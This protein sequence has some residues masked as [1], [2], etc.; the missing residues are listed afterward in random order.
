MITYLQSM[1]L[2]LLQGVSEL[3]PIS[4]LG[5]SV[6]FA[7][8]FGW[9]NIVKQ[10]ASTESFFL[11]YLVML[12][13]ATATALLIFYRKQWIKIIK[14]FFS[15]VSKRKAETS[16]EKLAWLLIVA[17]I[18]AGIFGL[19][20]EHMLRTQ[21]AKPLS[22]AIFI[23]INGFILLFGDYYI[24][25][26][27]IKKPKRDFLLDTSAKHTA[28]K[29]TF[30]RAG[31]IGSAQI[32]ALFAGISRSGVTIIGGIVTGLDYEDAARFSFLLA[33]PIILAAGLL[34]LPDFFGPLANGARP[35]ILAGALVAG[36]SAYFTVRFLD[37]Y[38][39]N[40]TLRPF[41][42]YCFALGI[43]MLLVG[44]LGYRQF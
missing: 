36:L 12:H 32:L 20:F 30:L 23:I 33:T 6:L 10:Q 35:Q 16:N 1:L 24:K 25:N 41:A 42:I 37:K 44:F 13:V 31:M 19:T 17:T 11:A 40:K 22:A 21:F 43:F 4:S 8:L 29:M 15:S 7:W 27:H 5:H 2:G 26:H 28:D 9:T 34:K 3:F 39:Q 38:F 18:P 14:G